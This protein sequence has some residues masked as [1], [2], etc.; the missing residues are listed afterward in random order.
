M[1]KDFVNNFPINAFLDGQRR[2]HIT[3]DNICKPLPLIKFNQT[4]WQK[5]FPKNGISMDN[6][7][8]LQMTKVGLYSIG[9]PDISDALTVF[10]KDQINKININDSNNTYNNITITETNGGL[11]GFSLALLRNFNTLNIVELNPTHY[12]IIKNNLALYGYSKNNVKNIT[13]Y[14]DNYINK[15]L[16]LQQDIIICDPPWG[17]RDYI[18]QNHIKLGI[19]NIDI[20]YIINELARHN[21]FKIFIFLAPRNYDFNS[22]LNIIDSQYCKTIEIKKIRHHYFVAITNVHI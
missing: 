21:K 18:K 4:Q 20:S 19:S 2:L 6:W 22:F 12:K 17:G 9:Q 8:K 5:L 14:N 11:G 1:N 13:I 16:V 15:M 7:K 10:V 3:D